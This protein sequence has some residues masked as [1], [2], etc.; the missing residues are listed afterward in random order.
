VAPAVPEQSAAG[1]TETLVGFGRALR[2]AGL[3][4]GTGEVMTLCAA[5]DPL[6]PT[7]LLDLY[8]GGRATLVT[9]HDQIP[10]YH[11]V[12]LRYFLDASGTHRAP[13]GPSR[14]SRSARRAARCSCPRP[15][16]SDAS[17]RRSA[18]R[19]DWSPPTSAP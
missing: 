9:R 3:P 17:E 18:H 8:W 4:V 14:P 13:S 16:V 2:D 7:D 5:M 10:V 6:D 12:F 15:S 19:W 1:L 11:D